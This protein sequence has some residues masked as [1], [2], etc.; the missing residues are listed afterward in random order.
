MSRSKYRLTPLQLRILQLLRDDGP[1]IAADLMFALPN[2][3]LAVA[4]ALQG[5]REAAL[6]RRSPLGVYRLTRNAR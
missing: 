5:L 3:H 6:V 4:L 1:A 2:R